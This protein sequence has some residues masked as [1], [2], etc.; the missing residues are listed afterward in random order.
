MS[1][2]ELQDEPEGPVTKSIRLTAALIL[3][4]LVTYTSSAKRTLRRYE[5][6]LANI[7][8]SNI[9][10]SGIVSNILFELSN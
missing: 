6:H 3:R 5:S 10:A 2:N 1:A 9:E 8:L 7:A 4:N